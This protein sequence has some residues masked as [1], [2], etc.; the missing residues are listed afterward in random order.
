MWPL[1]STLH[2]TKTIV[3]I[4][5]TLLFFTD[6]DLDDHANLPGLVRMSLQVLVL[7]ERNGLA[8]GASPD[9]AELK[10]AQRGDLP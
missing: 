1:L 5:F 10:C 7:H 2:P 8:A 3:V 9:R 4:F 6:G